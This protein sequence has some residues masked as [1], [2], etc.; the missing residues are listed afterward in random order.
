M[1]AQWLKMA[2]KFANLSVREK[3][4]ITLCSLTVVILGSYVF[5]VEPT[6]K[7]NQLLRQKLTAT[8]HSIQQLD[9]QILAISTKLK[10]DPDQGVNIEYQRLVTESQALS[11]QLAHVIENLISPS[12]MA[13]LLEDV[14]AG[15]QGLHL[16]SLES[17]KA[18]PIVNNN[19]SENYAGYYL[20]PVRLELTGGYFSVLNYLETLESLPVNYYWRSFN[21]QVNDYPNAT[22]IL[23]VYTLGTRQEFIGG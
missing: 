10:Q 7:S 8:N 9:D 23:E 20:H 22:L 17:L 15:T 3:W 18:E 21:Y 12:Q 16:V 1:K 11:E 5:F 6:V 14:L 4:L 19:A 2:E 13:T